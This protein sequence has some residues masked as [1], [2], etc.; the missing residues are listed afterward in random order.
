[1]SFEFISI[2]C[3]TVITTRLLLY[4]CRLPSPTVGTFRLHHYMY[5]LIGIPFAFVLHSLALYA[6]S[7][8]LFV[9]EITYLVIGGE[10]H[11]DNYSAFSLGGTLLLVVFVFI[12]K[13][14][15]V[16]LFALFSQMV[17]H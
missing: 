11:D 16:G 3:G 6:F 15:L 14:Q 5:G 8:A 12:F 2:F 4:F 7:A 10:S 1:M 9:D 13:E 17:A